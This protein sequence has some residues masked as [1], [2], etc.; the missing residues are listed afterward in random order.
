MSEV[1]IVFFDRVIEELDIARITTN[2]LDSSFA[3][4]KHLIECGCS[5]IFYLSISK[6]LAINNKRIEGFKKALTESAIR[7]NDGNI[8][9]CSNDAG[10]NQELLTDS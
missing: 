8:I 5:N 7:W 2:D 3:A 6:H 4:T 9:N 1:P 10:E